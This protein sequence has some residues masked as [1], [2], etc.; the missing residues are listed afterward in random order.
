MLLALD[1]GNSNV[2]IGVFEGSESTTAGGC[3]PFMNRRRTNGAS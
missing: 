2:T 1:V 3:A